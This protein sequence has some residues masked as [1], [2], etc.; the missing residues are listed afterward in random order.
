MRS[1]VSHLVLHYQSSSLTSSAWPSASRA[2]FAFSELAFPLETTLCSALVMHVFL[3]VITRKQIYKCCT[4]T[5]FSQLTFLS[6]HIYQ[7]S[8]ELTI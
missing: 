6:I 5:F 3:H 2:S 4:H 7:E 8:R 1:E